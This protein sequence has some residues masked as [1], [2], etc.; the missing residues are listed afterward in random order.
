MARLQEKSEPPVIRQSWKMTR[1]GPLLDESR[2][3]SR[4]SLPLG[5]VE[6]LSSRLNEEK[7]LDTLFSI[8]LNAEMTYTF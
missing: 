8:L 2:Q 6:R 5:T 4:S 3:A 1:A 7:V